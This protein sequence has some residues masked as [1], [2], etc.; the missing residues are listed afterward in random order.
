MSSDDSDK[1]VFQQPVPGGDRTVILP[2]PGGR[3]SAPNAG[4]VSPTVP[5]RPAAPQPARQPQPAPV[6]DR[7]AAYFRTNNGLN[8]LVNAASTLLAVFEK[9]RGTLSHPDVGGLHKRLGNEVRAFESQLRELGYKQETTIAARYIICTALDE[10]VLNT[11][12]GSESAW[13]QRTLLSVFHNETS[14]GEKSFVI[15]ERMGQAPMDNIDIIEFFYICLSLG[16]EGKYRFVARGRDSLDRIKDDLFSIIR[17]SRGEYERTLSAKWHGLGSVRKTLS[18]YIPTWVIVVVALALLFFSYTGF[19]YWLYQSATPV[20]DS[21]QAI[22]TDATP[23]KIDN[24]N[25]KVKTLKSKF[26]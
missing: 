8:G 12:W 11:P 17:R 7:E 18:H 25:D 26:E 24:K 19:R 20:A 16:F 6:V 21:L 3:G 1:T 5:P 4:Q 9:T 22:I 23:E 14:G 13:A 15:I 10:A 2:K